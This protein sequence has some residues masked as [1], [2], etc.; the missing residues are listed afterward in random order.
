[1]DATFDQLAAVRRL[2]DFGYS[3]YFSYDLTAA[4]DRL[5][6]LL[7]EKLLVPLLGVDRARDWRVILTGRYYGVGVGRL[8]KTK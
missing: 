6:V 2:V 4:T 1:M 3:K 5:P 8:N 7:Q